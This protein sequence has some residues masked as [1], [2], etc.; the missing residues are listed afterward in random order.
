M[1]QLAESYSE[2]FFS[3]RDRLLTEPR[4]VLFYLTLLFFPTPSR[5]SISH[6]I[7]LS[8]SLFNPLTTF[9]SILLI[10]VLLSVAIAQSKKNPIFSFSVLF[11]FL[12]HL[13]ESTFLPLELIFE[14]RNYLPS[15]F[16]FWPIVSFLAPLAFDTRKSNTKSKITK[17]TLVFLVVLFIF[18]TFQR[19][20]AWATQMT[21]WSDAIIKAPGRARPPFYIAQE[22]AKQGRI[23]EAI[24][25]YMK[26]LSLTVASPY[27]FRS[28]THFKIS[29][30]Y[31]NLSQFEEA[32]KHLHQAVEIKPSSAFF[33]YHLSLLLFKT[34]NIQES[35]S[36]INEII[37]DR[38]DGAL[39]H[40]LLAK[41]YI[42]TNNYSKAT[43]SLFKSIKLGSDDPE[44]LEDLSYSLFVT[45][46]SRHAY[47]VL[48]KIPPLHQPRC[49]TKIID[50]IEQIENEGNNIKQNIQ[51][52]LNTCPVGTISDTIHQMDTLGVTNKSFTSARKSIYLEL[53]ATDFPYQN[54]AYN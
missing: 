41:I 6:D 16:I 2:R 54:N 14:H 49:D 30:L 9:S 10:I 48:S 47:L 23:N 38:K 44:I 8:E 33:K 36:F 13:I 15:L 40:A 51:D 52:L 20:K 22:I 5:L 1:P 19:N 11:F 27:K 18:F 3:M 35:I 31:E 32:V 50:I 4:I 17:F 25:L 45:G 53:K 34:G 12:N 24:N 21:L 7:V 43:A 42:S 39:T 29:S 46:H 37:S 28:Y 26:S